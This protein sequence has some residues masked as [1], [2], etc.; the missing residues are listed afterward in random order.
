MEELG[1]VGM[2]GIKEILNRARLVSVCYRNKYL[3]FSKPTTEDY[4]CLLS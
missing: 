1:G 2:P 3:P 4:M